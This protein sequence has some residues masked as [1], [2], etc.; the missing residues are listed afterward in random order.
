MMRRV[1]KLRAGGDAATSRLLATWMNLIPSLQVR[2]PRQRCPTS[3]WHRPWHR[4]LLYYELEPSPWSALATPLR[5]KRLRQTHRMSLCQRPINTAIQASLTRRNHLL[6]TVNKRELWSPNLTMLPGNRLNRYA[7]L[8]AEFPTRMETALSKMSWIWR[9]NSHTSDTGITPSISF[10]QWGKSINK[11]NPEAR[12]ELL[13]IKST[14]C[15]GTNT[16]LNIWER[17]ISF[18]VGRIQ[19]DIIW[20][21]RG[22]E[23]KSWRVARKLMNQF[24]CWHPGSQRHRGKKHHNLWVPMLGASCGLELSERILIEQRNPEETED[25]LVSGSSKEVSNSSVSSESVRMKSK[26]CLK[27]ATAWSKRHNHHTLVQGESRLMVTPYQWTQEKCGS[28]QQT[29][30]QTRCM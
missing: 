6:K 28:R 4:S 14:V 2:P 26:P 7:K 1:K 17:L 22:L 23:S 24:R 21:S 9:S 8:Q 18:P 20:W 15:S 19:S 29:A 10:G 5:K 30:L 11:G 16:S 27:S 3:P 25:V 13:H 12:D